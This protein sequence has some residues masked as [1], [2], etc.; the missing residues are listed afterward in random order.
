MHLLR[1][2]SFVNEHDSIPKYFHVPPPPRRSSFTG[3]RISASI[4]LPGTYPCTQSSK[5]VSF[6][7]CAVP[8]LHVPFLNEHFNRLLTLGVSSYMF[9]IMRER[10]D[11]TGMA[12]IAEVKSTTES[13]RPQHILPSLGFLERARTG[14]APARVQQTKSVVASETPETRDLPARGKA[15]RRRATRSTRRAASPRA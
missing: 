6:S 7:I 14:G 10:V 11:V 12:I 9:K 4:G 2:S 15:R 5:R 13:S 3:P 8:L 1:P